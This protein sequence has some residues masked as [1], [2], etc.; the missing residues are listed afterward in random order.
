MAEFQYPDWAIAAAEG[1][2]GPPPKPPDVDPDR[3]EGL[4]NGFLAATHEALH[5]APDAFYRTTGQD[6]VEAVPAVQDRPSQ[7]PD[8]APRGAKA[9][10]DRAALAPPPHPPPANCQA[11]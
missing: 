4:Q 3:I 9:A 7:L 1:R 10:G 8:A 2:W 6:A 5:D 11:R